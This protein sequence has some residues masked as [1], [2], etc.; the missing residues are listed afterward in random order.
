MSDKSQFKAG[1]HFIKE[2]TL[3][4]IRNQVLL[5]IFEQVEEKE[6]RLLERTHALEEMVKLKD[7]ER[8]LLET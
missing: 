7:E 5:Q 3:M 4:R 8:A 1:E 6:Q 2:T